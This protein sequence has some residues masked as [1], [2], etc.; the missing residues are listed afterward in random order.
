MSNPDKDAQIKALKDEL[1][2]MEKERKAIESKLK[3]HRAVLDV[4]STSF[5]APNSYIIPDYQ[6]NHPFMV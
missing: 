5:G 3:D 6:T 2:N 1:M 4:V